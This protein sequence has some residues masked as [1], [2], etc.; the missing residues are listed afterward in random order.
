MRVQRNVIA[1]DFAKLMR[2][3]RYSYTLALA[4]YFTGKENYA[5]QAAKIV[6]TFFLD[7]EVG[8]RPHLKYAQLNPAKEDQAVGESFVRI[9]GADAAKY[10]CAS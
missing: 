1:P 7:P 8:M 9:P 5:R 3:Q 2:V 4:W 10:L 6:R